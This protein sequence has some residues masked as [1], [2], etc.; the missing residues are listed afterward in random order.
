MRDLA[1]ESDLIARDLL[2]VLEDGAE[3]GSG[4][5]MNTDIEHA[6]SRHLGSLGRM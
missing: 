1:P 2:V 5:Q 3:K 6:R 4:I